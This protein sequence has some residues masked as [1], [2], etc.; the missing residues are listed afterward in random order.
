MFSI[1]KET[2]F[3]RCATSFLLLSVQYPLLRSYQHK[4][5]QRSGNTAQCQREL[6]LVG[7]EFIWTVEEK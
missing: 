6:R 5:P 4:A 7:E 2:V 1:G 3:L